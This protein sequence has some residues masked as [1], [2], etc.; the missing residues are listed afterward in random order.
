MSAKPAG[1]LVRIQ[2]D[3]PSLRDGDYLRTRS[4]RRYLVLAVRVQQHGKH[5]GRQH[6]S[7]VVVAPDHPIE[8]DARVRTIQWYK[9]GP[10]R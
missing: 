6:V 9:R 3:G 10:R 1:S 4:G 8:P 7:A 2:Y 5:K